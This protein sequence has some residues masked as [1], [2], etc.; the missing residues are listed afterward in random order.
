[1]IDDGSNESCGNLLAVARLTLNHLTDME[2]PFFVGI[3]LGTNDVVMVV[4][5]V[6]G[7]DWAP[8]IDGFAE[9]PY[10]NCGVTH[11]SIQSG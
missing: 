8:A 1:M 9:E 4:T 2:F 5:P 10:E 3:V 7:I 11:L 6:N